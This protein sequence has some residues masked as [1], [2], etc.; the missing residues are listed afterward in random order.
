MRPNIIV[1]FTDQQRWDTLGLNGNP[2]D[3]TPNFDRL[4]RTGS[5][6]K[7]AVTCQPVCG[8]ARSCL[9]TGLYASQTGVWCNGI[10][11]DSEA[12]T[13][14]KCFRQGGYRTG[15][16]GK[17]HLAGKDEPAGP[18]R[19]ELRGGYEDWLAAEIVEAT[20][21]PYSSVLWNESEKPVTL[22]GYR[23]DAHVDAAIRYLAK[24]AE[25]PEQP[26]FLCLSL[27]EPHQQNS[28]DS[29]PAPHGYA[30][31]FKGRWCPPDLDALD[32][33]AGE[34]LAGYC[35]M[36]Y[37]VDEALGRMMDA[38]YSLEL[39]ENTIVAFISDHGCHF[40]TRNH[41]YKRTPHES[42]V[43]IPLSLWGHVF[44][45][46]GEFSEAA[47]L[48]DLAPTL[49][50]AA[51]L[52]I[53]SCMA[54]RSL[55]DLVRGESAWSEDSYIQFGDYGFPCGHALRTH[56]W[57]YAVSTN[58][59][60][61]EFSDSD[62]YVESHLYNLEDDPYELYNLVKSQEHVEL[63]AMLRKRLLERMAAMGSRGSIS[64]S[65]PISSCD[66]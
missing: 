26:F 29:Y 62:E 21:G 47:S 54:G 2:L 18:V 1:F 65:Y 14:A 37:K 4:S 33:N 59:P 50:D 11:M 40:K 35:G 3:L 38:L 20:S 23:V 34:H 57:K 6:F 5:F 63:R 41:E 49:L 51:E 16:I 19:P 46:G 45:G 64:P 28:T 10:A 32:G 58:E 27:L 22:P 42:S 61:T 36:V 31:R 48:V 55:L 12:Q 52:P 17:W 56:R 9:Q 7:N 8:P 60:R 30:E 39:S 44:D 15:Y 24:R 25:D 13:L 53:P 43:R 66:R